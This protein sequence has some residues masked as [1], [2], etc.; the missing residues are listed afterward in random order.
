MPAV[1][2][3]ARIARA[4]SRRPTPP[5]VLYGKTF[6]DKYGARVIPGFRQWVENIANGELV[7]ARPLGFGFGFGLGLA[8]ALA[9]GLGWRTSPTASWSAPGRRRPHAPAARAARTRR[10]ARGGAALMPPALGRWASS[11]SSA[12]V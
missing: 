7:C 1:C 3:R 6:C 12:S 9:L 8:L 10:G 2:A 4:P 11:L 5:Q